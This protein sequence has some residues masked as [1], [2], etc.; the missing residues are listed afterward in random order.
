MDQIDDDMV[1]DD[2]H[3]CTCHRNPPCS[4][5]ENCAECAEE[6]L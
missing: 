4:H 5:C 6:G 1:M 3:D 2:G